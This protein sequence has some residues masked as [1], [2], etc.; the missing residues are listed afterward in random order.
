MI[1]KVMPIFGR[2][3]TTVA[4]RYLLDEYPAHCGWAFKK[5][6]NVYVGNCIQVIRSTDNTTLDIGFVDNELDTASLLSFAGIGDARITIWYDQT[7]NGR[8]LT[9]GNTSQR[10]LIVQSGI[11]LTD[12]SEPY[13]SIETTFTDSLRLLTTG[14]NSATATLFG[15]YNSS[16]VTNGM[17]LTAGAIVNSTVFIGALQNSNTSTSS[18]NAGSSI[19]YYENGNLIGSNINRNLAYDNYVLGQDVLFSMTNIS[20]INTNWNAKI[21]PFQYGASVFTQ[22]NKAKIMVIYNDDQSS[23]RT[24]IESIIQKIYNTV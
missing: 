5:L 22:D 4:Y 1:N 9:I 10:P 19:I 18:L 17:I 16:D 15:L 13:C 8:N 24:D 7:G 2:R 11:L 14:L 20:F 21:R 6:S 3:N 12:S 23:N